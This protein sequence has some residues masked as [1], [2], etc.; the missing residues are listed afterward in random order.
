MSKLTKRTIDATKPGERETFEWDDELRGFGLRVK[1]SGVKTYVVQYRTDT[2]RTRRLAIGQV[3]RLTPESARKE[4]RELLGKVDKGQDPSA[5]RKAARMAPDVGR[6]MDRYLS[7]H[8]KRHNRASTKAEVNRLIEKH[9]KPAMG[10]LKTSGITRQDVLKFQ[11]SLAETPRQ[12]NHALAILSKAFNL[13]EAWGLRPEGANPCRHVKKYPEIKRER[14]LSADELAR[15]GAELR[16]IEAASL[17]PWPVIGVIRFLALTGLRLGEAIGLRWEAV[18]TQCGCVFLADGETKAGARAHP[19]GSDA[20]EVLGSLPRADRSPWVFSKG[21][22]DGPVKRDAMEKAWQRIRTICGFEDARLHDLRHTVGT[23]AG[24]GGANAFMVR[25]MLGHKT[26]AMTDRYVN[27][28]ADPV[29]ALSNRVAS[30]I[31]AAMAGRPGTHI[32][33]IRASVKAKD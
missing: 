17:Q 11:G 8:V 19:L 25:D 21:A 6:L 3:G 23:V 33:P 14:F 16:R 32:V 4:A 31:S 15:L 2:G 9:I 5:E 28:A 22:S 7:E 1:P 27:R 18:D 30:E 29:K 12:A 20:L 10:S 26:L 13:A 24:Q